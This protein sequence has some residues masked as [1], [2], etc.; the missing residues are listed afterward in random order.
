MTQ[1]TWP[2][3]KQEAGI[4][5]CNVLVIYGSGVCI[6]DNISYPPGKFVPITVT[7]EYGG[8]KYVGQ[9]RFTPN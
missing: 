8:E 2:D 9:T 1:A 4:P 3:E 7:I 6:I 5:N